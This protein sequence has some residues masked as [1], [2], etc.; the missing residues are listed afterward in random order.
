MQTTFEVYKV[1]AN[2][3]EYIG[4]TPIKEQAVSAAKTGARK[5]GCI[6]EVAMVSE[7]LGVRTVA[8]HSN[9]IIERLW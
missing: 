2:S 1:H 6:Y 4:K 8:Y 9:G 7:H 3:R 5:N